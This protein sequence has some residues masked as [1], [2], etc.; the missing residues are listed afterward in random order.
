MSE[1]ESVRLDRRLSLAAYTM[2]AVGYGL[3]LIGILWSILAWTAA[4]DRFDIVMTV[5][6]MVSF[7]LPGVAFVNSG[8]RLGRAYR[9][10]MQIGF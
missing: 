1:S 3:L 6:G 7:T 5:T 10:R 4:Q 2:T 8:R 9:A